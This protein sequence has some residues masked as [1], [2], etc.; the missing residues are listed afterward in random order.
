MSRIAA[1]F[2][3]TGLLLP[4]AV[5]AQTGDIRWHLESGERGKVQLS[6]SRDRNGGRDRDSNDWAPQ[7]LQGLGANPYA[8]GT[9]V[10][11]RIVRPVGVLACEGRGRGG[12]AEGDCRF[13]RDA[14]YFDGLR[15]RGVSVTDEWLAWQLA[16][17]DVP[18]ALLDELRRLGY[19]TPSIRDLISAGIFKVDVA[20]LRA[21]DAAGY[22]LENVR[23]L[24]PL[25]IHGVSA[26]FI[27]GMKTANPRLQLS[28]KELVDLRIHGA[29]PEWVA[30]WAQLGYNLSA[31]EIVNTRIHGASPDYARAMMAEVRDRPTVQQFINMRIHGVRPGKVNK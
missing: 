4:L 21:L 26:D 6:L 8:N 9:E 13:D 16:R 19:E 30:G 27:R 25:R 3:S 20:Y 15:T 2:L 18:L 10:S 31:R 1:L 12:H 5:Q 28:P 11:F 29:T 7:E 24:I 17:F 23:A 22:R 14:A